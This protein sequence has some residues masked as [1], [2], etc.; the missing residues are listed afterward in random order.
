MLVEVVRAVMTAT[1]CC[2]LP[3]VLVAAALEDI[4]VQVRRE[5]Q[6]RAAAVVVA[7]TIYRHFIMALLAVQAL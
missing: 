4:L 3:V 2:S 6:I 1:R 5:R 7:L